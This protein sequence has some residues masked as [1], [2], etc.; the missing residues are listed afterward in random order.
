[1]RQHVDN[2]RARVAGGKVVYFVDEFFA[3]RAEILARLGSQTQDHIEVVATADEPETESIERRVSA[4][5]EGG[6]NQLV[7]IVAIRG[8]ITLDTAKAVAVDFH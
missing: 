8:G 4:L 6:F 5:I 1:L 2:R 3:H 7:T